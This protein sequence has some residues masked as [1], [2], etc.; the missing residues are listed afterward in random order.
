[1]ICAAQAFARI[2]GAELPLWVDVEGHG[3]GAEHADFANT[4][5]WFTELKQLCLEATRIKSTCV[6]LQRPVQC[7]AVQVSVAMPEALLENIER[8]R[9]SSAVHGHNVQPTISFN[10]HGQAQLFPGA[11][12]LAEVKN[13]NQETTHRDGRQAAASG[14]TRSF[15]A[16]LQSGGPCQSRTWHWKTFGSTSWRLRPAWHLQVSSF[17]TKEEVSGHARGR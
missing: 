11:L 2:A 8:C 10:Y 7:M 1:M 16:W 6:T 12:F 13:K 17:G 15:S 3:R 14:A 5:G 4:V 9:S